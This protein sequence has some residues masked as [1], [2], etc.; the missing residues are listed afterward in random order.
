ML[1]RYA[2]ILRYAFLIYAFLFL[3]LTS[4]SPLNPAQALAEESSATLKIATVD[5]NRVMNELA[6]A[7]AKKKELEAL[8]SGAK[9]KL[10]AQ[11][12][13]LEALE[14][15][16]KENKLGDDSE[17]AAKF[18]RAA[19]EFQDSA[20]DAEGKIKREFMKVNKT[21]SEKV[22]KAIEAYSKANGVDV[23]LDKSPR[24]GNPVLFGDASA[25]ITD[26]IIKELSR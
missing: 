11:R 17:D 10:E 6:E 23:V 1:T 8:S 5:I 12:K 15:K 24:L 3:S 19:R 7:K 20:S 25:D 26:A 16:I 22:L 2:V 13:N 18:R 4:S 9:V 21:L 14:K